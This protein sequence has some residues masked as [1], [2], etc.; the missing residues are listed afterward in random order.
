MSLLLL[1]ALL[2]ATPSADTAVG[3]W[4]SP[5]KN[6]IIDVEKC[7][8]SLCGHL[9]SS[10]GIKADPGLKDVNNK[11][12]KL[13]SRPLKGSLMLSGFRRDGN[14]WVDGSVYN[15]ND[16]RTYGGKITIIDANSIKL[17]GCVFVPLCKTETWT[18]VR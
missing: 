7:G 6:A 16:G 14:D 9:V 12:P 3:T 10:D 13:Q 1:A 4:R 15:G 8:A 17:R 5:T 18:R 11:D 2:A